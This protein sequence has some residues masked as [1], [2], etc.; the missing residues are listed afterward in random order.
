MVAIRT[1]RARTLSCREH[2]WARDRAHGNLFAG[3]GT[4]DM[5][6]RSAEP[7]RPKSIHAGTSL[8]DVLQ[9]AALARLAAFSK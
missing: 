8:G 2:G 3:G 4:I 5:K 7:L 9:P 6:R 1:G